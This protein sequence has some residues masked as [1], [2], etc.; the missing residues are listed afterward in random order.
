MIAW[1]QCDISQASGYHSLTQIARVI[2]ECWC[3][4]NLYCASCSAEAL[5]Q[6]PANTRALDFRCRKCW[7]TYQVK[8]QKQLKLRRIV[9]GAYSAM[10][11]A[12][13]QNSAPNLVILNYS[14]TW[15]IQN[16]VLVPSLF[17]TESVIERTNPLSAKAERVGWIGCNLIL[18]NGP[19]DGKISLVENAVVVPAGTVRAAYQRYKK[20]ASVDSALRGWT[21]DVLSVAR[22]LGN[23][24]TLD[25]MYAHEA[26]LASL[27]PQNQNIRPKI[28]QQ[29]QVLRDLSVLRFLG[30]G[31]YQFLKAPHSGA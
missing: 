10:L 24:F 28:R 29:L 23:E 15:T 26:G 2:S 13:Q 19:A 25:Q 27:H 3:S 9:D 21:F 7:E 20:L 14:S 30:D 6:A 1:L 11:S 16:L 31:K 18:S 5:E 17:L 12:V 22:Q 4:Q 8:S